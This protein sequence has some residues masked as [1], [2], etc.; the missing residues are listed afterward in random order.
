[1]LEDLK[2]E[3]LEC[4][5]E[6]P[7]SGLVTG[8][9]GNV[10]ARDATTGLIVIKPSGVRYDSLS[11]EDMVVVD[12]NGRKIEGRLKPSSDTTSHLVVYKHKSNVLGIAHTHSNFAT[13]FAVVGKP[14]IP[15]LT[16]IAEEFGS[17][18]P[19][20]DFAR[21]GGEEIGDEIIRSIG[22]C[23]AILMRNHGIFTLGKS[24]VE[25]TNLAV[26]LEDVAKTTWLAMQI[27]QPIPLDDEEIAY[28]FRWAKESYGQESH[29]LSDK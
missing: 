8:T 12:I 17:A 18:I 13:A 3:V 16:M 7:K 10:S 21:I 9:C 4:N 26:T 23:P 19:V 22:S 11:A 24:P 29:S 1:M 25:A 14:I 20:S 6:L 27:G 15:C 5:L 28:H 2:Q